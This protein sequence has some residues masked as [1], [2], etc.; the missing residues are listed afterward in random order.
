MSNF[1]NTQ[2]RS[3]RLKEQLREMLNFIFQTCLDG[4][5]LTFLMLD[6]HSPHLEYF[7]ADDGQ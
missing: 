1:L 4:D 3:I 6:E 7:V 5:L 2:L